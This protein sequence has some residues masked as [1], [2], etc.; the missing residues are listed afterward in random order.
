MTMGQRIQKIRELR[1]MTQ[2]EL[3]RLTN[4]TKQTIFKY[5][6]GIVT[7]IPIDRLEKIAAALDVRAAYLLG[8]EMDDEEL[9]RARDGLFVELREHPD[10][11]SGQRVD[12]L[13]SNSNLDLNALCNHLNISEDVIM[14]WINFNL[15]P[16]RAVVDR[17]LSVFSLRPEELF[18]DDEINA[19]RHG[20]EHPMIAIRSSRY[21]LV[22]LVG[23]IAC[24]SP[25]LAEE[26]TEAMV[27]LPD[28]VRA[29]FALRCK[30]NSMIKAR[31]CDGDIVYIR[32]QP[33]VENGEIAAVLI[34]DE[35]TL[36]RYYFSDDQL[37]LKPANDD[38][39]SFYFRDLELEDV[40]ILGKA[41][42]FTSTLPPNPFS[43]NP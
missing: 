36:K 18:P 30:G 9:R 25:I 14:N 13:F 28:G 29:D 35:A 42:A 33:T 31:I 19:Y 16:Q 17:F 20:S 1:N 8:W 41:V 7:N 12:A 11:Q 4:T 43:I 2:E 3:G 39:P 34:G 23:T 26:N 21:A 5:E 10:M 37:I 22:P 15:I 24:G 6:R 40:R 38:V 32:Q 27:P